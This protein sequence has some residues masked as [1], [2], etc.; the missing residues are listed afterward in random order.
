MDEMVGSLT[1]Q[2]SLV[3][4]ERKYFLD[5]VSIGMFDELIRRKLVPEFMITDL[6][7]DQIT[8][9]KTSKIVS[10]MPC[11]WTVEM[12]IE[13]AICTLNVQIV[14]SEFGFALRDAH[15]QNVLFDNGHA[16]F[17][18]FDSFVPCLST[19]HWVASGEYKTEIRRPITLALS[20]HDS[21]IRKILEHHETLNTERLWTLQ[22][23]TLFKI[24]KF[25][26]L[27]SPITVLRERLALLG[28]FNFQNA[29]IHLANSGPDL[30]LV[31]SSKVKTFLKQ[32][33]VLLTLSA[34]CIATIIAI[35]PK[36]EIRRLTKLKSNNRQSG[37]WSNYYDNS[38]ATES[39]NRFEVI[40][41]CIEDLHIESVT[42]VG[43]NDGY[44][45]SKLMLKKQIN[46]YVLLDFDSKSVE[47]ARQQFMSEE[48]K[49]VV[50]VVNIA[51]PLKPSIE[52]R[53]RFKSDCATALALTHHLTLR[54]RMQFG[55]ALDSLLEYTHRYLL[56]EYMPLGLWDGESST[57][58][59]EWY[60]ESNFVSALETRT[61][62]LRREEVDFNRVLFVCERLTRD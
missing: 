48:K 16:F 21:I 56:V 37:Y 5:A 45:L 13:A 7:P 18:D 32:F 41:S 51:F 23:P 53:N 1:R 9:I 35:R 49:T 19:S 24:A 59:P 4:Q 52:I 58:V 38:V 54:H 8:T 34:K 46:N 60:S 44:F 12:M 61:R 36:R 14:A 62:V 2:R 55:E 10:A 43:G 22:Y 47:W 30:A 25:F 28:I 39:T 11:E 31:N 20:G 29:V 15:F 6:A 3:G 57:K 42:D 40:Y 26:N 50:G 33:A 17:I 27:S